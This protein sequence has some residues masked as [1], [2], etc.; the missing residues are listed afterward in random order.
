MIVYTPV[1]GLEVH[2]EL[3]TSTKM[4]C[5]SKNDSDEVRPNVNICP[6]CMA[7][8][9]TL[10][11]INK[12][13]VRSVLKVGAAIGSRL[14]DYTEFDR[15][16]YFYPDLPKGYQLSQYE[17]P[18]VSGGVLNDVAITRIHLEEDTASSIHD[19]TTGVTSIDYNRAGVPLMELVTEPVITSAE[20]AGD[21]ARELQLLLRYL[22]VS[23][24]N[25]EKGEMRVE[26]NVS[27]SADGVVSTSYVELKNI[28]SFRTMEKA[29]K[30]EISRQKEML[31]RGEIILKETRGWDDARQITFSQRVKEGGADY[32]YF[33]DPDLPS[34]K[35]SE[36]EGFSADELRSTLPELPQQRRM[37]YIAAG[38][39]A[40]D[41]DL[42]V[43]DTR[44]GDFIDSVSKGEDAEFVLTAS[45]Y[46]ANDLVKN[47]RDIEERDTSILASLPISA[48]NFGILIR[49]IVAGQLSSRAAK[50]VLLACVLTG[51]NPEEYAKI[52]N[53]VQSS[54]TSSLEATVMKII[55]ANPAV[56]ADVRAGKGP[57]L[58]F[59]LG[60]CMKELRGAGNPAVLRRLLVEKT[61]S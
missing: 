14:A 29:V 22:G 51:E 11:V 10:P 35:L 50:D 33:P 57:A 20:Q 54:D 34:L 21:F 26:A 55:G 38:I 18:L 59:L 53:L 25:M 12:E 24:A 48:E 6:V 9:G 2:A 7:H 46:I 42:Y 28:N 13:A 23:D 43:R 44:L 47:L 60:Q 36:M 4:F 3:R 8:P 39:K 52:H 5:C 16:N 17:Y 56:V 15:K 61:S 40:D 27:V 32:R 49:M 45:N 58:E 37:R 1:I 30:Y 31:E 19:D 41:A